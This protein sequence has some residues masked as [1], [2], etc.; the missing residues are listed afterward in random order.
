MREDAVLREISQDEWGEE[1]EDIQ[2]NQSS[3]TLILSN[4]LDFTPPDPG[5]LQTAVEESVIQDV[6]E[7]I[8]LSDVETELSIDES[9]IFRL[10]SN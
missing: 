1:E 5:F 10:G 4:I 2:N 8:E 7:L 3:F 9:N 6:I